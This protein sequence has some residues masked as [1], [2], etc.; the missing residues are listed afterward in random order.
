MPAGLVELAW[1]G[2][3]PS[4]S[5]R[6][7]GFQVSVAGAGT[8]SLDEEP[9]WE[10]VRFDLERPARIHGVTVAWA[11]F[12]ET[13]ISGGVPLSIGLY[14]DFGHNGVDYWRDSAYWEGSRC[15]GD[16]QPLTPVEY[17]LDEPVEIDHPGLVYI[18]HRAELPEDPTF[19]W[20][21]TPP[22]D[23]NIPCP[24]F[25]A[26]HSGVN[27]PAA[28]DE[29]FYQGS[30]FTFPYDFVV[31][32][33]VEWL[34]EVAPEERAFQ[35][36]GLPG[37]WLRMAWGDYDGDGWDDLFT[38]EIDQPP[39]LWKNSGGET[40]VDVTAAA[41]LGAADP[42]SSGVW[43]DY[44]NDGCLDLYLFNPHPHIPNA[45]YHSNCD[46]T[47]TDVTA[48]AGP[49]SSELPANPC[50]SIAPQTQSAAWID[51][52]SD[53]FLDLYVANYN[54]G[55]SGYVFEDQVFRNL[56]DGTFEDWSGT[57]GFLDVQLNGR[58]TSPIDYDQDGDVDLLVGNYVL[59]RNLF[60]RNLG[61]GTVEEIALT[62]GLAGDVTELQGRTYYGHTLG[63][64]WGDLDGDGDFDLVESNLAHPRFFHFSDRTR[65]LLHD[66]PSGFFF[67]IAGGG[68]ALPVSFAGL[69]Y[70]EA[71]TVPV[72]GDFDLDGDLDLA[73]S[74][75]YEYTGRPT[76]FYWG[77]GDGTFELESF[78]TLVTE[79]GWGM[80]A[81][82]FDKDGD[83]DL[84][85]RQGLF[86]NDVETAGHWLSVRAVGTVSNRAAI[87]ATVR[88]IAGSR[89][90]VGHVPGGSN[91]GSQDSQAVHF[92]L[93][94]VTQVDR[95][96]IQFPGGSEAVYDGP[97]PV[98]Q[99]LVL[100]EP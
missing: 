13:T 50:G 75:R 100:A 63:T 92:G 66:A 74:G 51:V 18:A 11:N 15:A 9:L 21:T 20:D 8:F 54:C 90:F 28:G 47:F 40:F 41:G 83:L 58:T 70:Q 44:D 60:Y 31:R 88:A 68:S 3:N 14:P 65:V 25:D 79:D 27:L 6:G 52:D 16:A 93:G 26:C 12:D 46:G 33:H 2:G 45:L 56:G 67:D 64:A 78:R 55:F 84:M 57:N 7:L 72:L 61:D 23:P 38:S 24:D 62:N 35:P 34:D 37:P 81:A 94:D 42:Y 99:E 71:H 32:L 53:S 49:V 86:R 10:G 73:I 19:A 97:F 36:A 30:S 85:T 59:D 91:Q 43:G 5:I 96:E 4:E 76:D 1:D 29:L 17:V 95:V 98:D 87:G 39:V 77:N 89:T 69:R 80:A 22:D 82:D 48:A